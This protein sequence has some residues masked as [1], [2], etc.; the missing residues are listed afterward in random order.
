MKHLIQ[1]ILLVSLGGLLLSCANRMDISVNLRPMPDVDIRRY[2][3]TWH[4]I[5]RIPNKYEKGLN[6]VTA[7]YHLRGDYR[8]AIKNAGY[9]EKGELEYVC[10]QGYVPNWKNPGHLRVSFV[11]PFHWFYGDYNILY[12]NKSY[13]L[14]L[15][16][17]GDANYL[18]ILAKRDHISE[19][20][21]QDL[22]G[23]ARARGFD[24]SRLIWPEVFE[25]KH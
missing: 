7:T 16:S 25:Y 20:E 12:V 17:G 18:W 22:L 9:N 11:I 2:A 5:A 23:M 4:E 15:V 1:L 14:A 3:G 8:F 19:A 13:D 21:K 10:G 6:R 24:T